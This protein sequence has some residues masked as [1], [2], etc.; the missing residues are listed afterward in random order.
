M[1]DVCKNDLVLWSLSAGKKLSNV[2]SEDCS[3]SSKSHPERRAI[4]EY[5][6][7]ANT[8]T[9]LIKTRKTNWDFCLD[10]SAG[11]AHTKVR[12]GWQI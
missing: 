6:C 10:F 9:L 4:A 12:S 5:F 2:M 8:Q 7:C 1:T 11:E 3:K